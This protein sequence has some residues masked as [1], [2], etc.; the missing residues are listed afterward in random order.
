MPLSLQ[1]KLT[2]LFN[3]NNNAPLF[4]GSLMADYDPAKETGALGSIATLT[5]QH[6]SYDGTAVGDPQLVLDSSGKRAVELDGTD[7]GYTLTDLGNDI[8][9]ND[10]YCI[11]V[12]VRPLVASPFGNQWL[13]GGSGG[14]VSDNL[15]LGYKDQDNLGLHHWND[16][17]ADTFSYSQNRLDIL[18]FNQTSA[19]GRTIYANGATVATG[20]YDELTSN[21]GW[22]MARRSNG[23]NF[24]NVRI[25]R[26]LVYRGLTTSEFTS[27]HDWLDARYGE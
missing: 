15:H 19:G 6:G 7:D 17:I 10:D 1:R 3:S 18:V 21:N 4:S 26:C 14:S 16:D 11:A 5:D 20:A 9:T 24:A 27:V 12:A 25:L 23:G 13:F 22:A 8:A 2:L